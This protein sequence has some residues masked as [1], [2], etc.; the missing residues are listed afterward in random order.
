[1]TSFGKVGIQISDFVSL[2]IRTMHPDKFN[3]TIQIS[4]FIRL[5]TNARWHI[6]TS[7]RIHLEFYSIQGEFSSL[8]TLGLKHILS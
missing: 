1:M 8:I 7:S 3:V 5:W 4:G 2:E 6:L